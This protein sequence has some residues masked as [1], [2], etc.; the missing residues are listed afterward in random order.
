LVYDSQ[1]YENGQTGN[2][3]GFSYGINVDVNAKN[4]N[5][6]TNSNV[7]RPYVDLYSASNNGN[8]SSSID[9][10]SVRFTANAELRASDLFGRESKLAKIIGRHVLTGLVAEDQNKTQNVNWQGYATTLD[11]QNRLQ[12]APTTQISNYRKFD[13][14]VY[15]GSS[16]ISTSSVSGLNLSPVSVVVAP[17]P[18]QVVKYF[19]VTYKPTAPA[20][21]DPFTYISPFTGLSVTGTQRDNP[22]NYVGWEDVPITWLNHNNPADL[23]ALVTGGS[24]TSFKDRSKGFI[25]QG[26]FLDGDLVPTWGWRKDTV[27]NNVT[28]APRSGASTFVSTDYAYDPTKTLTTEGTTK[29]Y[30]GVY[31]LPKFLTRGLPY[32]TRISVLYNKNQNFIATAPRMGLGGAQLPNPN[33]DTKEYGI[34]INTLDNKLSF[35]VTKYKTLVQN[36]TLNASNVGGL[37]SQGY[38]IWAMP[39][40][41]HVS[42]TALQ[43]GMLGNPNIGYDQW[44]YGYI[45]QSSG[46]AG[47]TGN[48][49]TYFNPSDP[50]YAQAQGMINAWLNSPFDDAY[51]AAWAMQPNA[52]VPSRA[53][54]SGFLRDAYVGGPNLFGP[55]YQALTFATQAPSPRG[56]V[57]TVDTL[58]EG[59]EYEV[60]AQPIKNWNITVNY[61]R[62]EASR[63]NIDAVTK[64]F[65]NAANTWLKTTPAGDLPLIGTITTT[66]ATAKT[67]WDNYVWLPYQVILG[68]QGQAAPEVATW[69]FNGVT[70]YTFDRGRFKNFTVGGAARL[71]AGRILG[72][73]FN[74]TTGI[75]DVTKP[76]MGP[77]DEHFDLWL[78]YSRKICSDK[79]TWRI[80]AN[81]RNVG[82]KNRLVAAQINPDGTYALMR[83][84]QG[85][86]WQL[87]NSFDF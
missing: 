87:T 29:A 13:P 75:L 51:W 34:M 41:W 47:H 67:F 59:Y 23:P 83:I 53:K 8:S 64:T 69:R 80:Q 61:S 81:I 42:A 37:G 35:K 43:E 74:P 2:L 1:Q 18:E 65:M 20:Q 27:Y 45:L 10:H 57:T 49:P 11:W 48:T 71:E 58:S 56:P 4:S 36:A 78:G 31:H 24:R 28:S 14:V 54:A 9:R 55:G 85:M 21:T 84:Q 50:A 6:S 38:F 3:Q 66:A 62:T 76:W 16:L 82:E 30:G 52:M 12:V 73:Q 40:W 39:Q 33:G 72:Y 22:A 26:Y 5:G 86:T 77:S 32:N 68:Q 63:S 79:V 25:Y 17:P 60:S 46:I 70:T 15:L 44:N 7:G 19:N